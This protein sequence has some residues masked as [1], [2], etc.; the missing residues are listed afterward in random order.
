MEVEWHA[1]CGFNSMKLNTVS[2]EVTCF[3]SCISCM[4]AL[5]VHAHQESDP[6]SDGSGQPSAAWNWTQDL[7]KSGQVLLLTSLQP[8]IMYF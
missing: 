6:S 1:Q 5:C 7:W 8:Q 2:N 3:Y 4:W